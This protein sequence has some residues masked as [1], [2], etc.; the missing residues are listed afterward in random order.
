[1]QGIRQGVEDAEAPV[2][3]GGL[4]CSCS[5]ICREAHGEGHRGLGLQKGSHICLLIFW[6][7]G[8]SRDSVWH[9]IPLWERL[10]RHLVEGDHSLCCASPAG[11]VMQETKQECVRIADVLVQRPKTGFHVGW[12]GKSGSCQ[13]ETDFFVVVFSFFSEI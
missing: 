7:F 12:V 5:A 4:R 13:F 9:Q 2:S 6:G 8:K 11:G 3:S 1:M 10:Y